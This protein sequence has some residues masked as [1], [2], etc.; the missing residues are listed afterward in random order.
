MFEFGDF[1]DNSAYIVNIES[2]EVVDTFYI[3]PE[4]QESWTFSG[5]DICFYGLS[6]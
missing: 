1:A 4:T 2:G 3:N 6:Y 5:L